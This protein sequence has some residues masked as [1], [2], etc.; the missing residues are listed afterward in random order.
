MAGDTW[1]ECPSAE[2]LAMWCERKLKDAER[3][4]LESHLVKCD[5]CRHTV[6]EVCFSMDAGVSVDCKRAQV[7][8]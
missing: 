8:H 3:R 5:R 4:A 6:I 7:R 2:M 1:A